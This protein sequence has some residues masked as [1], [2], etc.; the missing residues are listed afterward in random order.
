ME[1]QG[2]I[3]EHLFFSH[4]LNTNKLMDEKKIEKNKKSNLILPEARNIK[5]FQKT[6]LKN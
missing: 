6:P 3:D 1:A 4:G 2:D 5:I